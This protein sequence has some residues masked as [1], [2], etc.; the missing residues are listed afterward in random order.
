MDER[1]EP[2]GKI[3]VEMKNTG[4]RR[5]KKMGA[6]FFELLAFLQKHQSFDVSVCIV[7]RKF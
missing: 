4:A 6:I 5:S 3:W 7:N 2:R 1:H